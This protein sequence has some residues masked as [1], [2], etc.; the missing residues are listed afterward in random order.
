[1]NI[2]STLPNLDEI[3]INSGTDKSSKK[4]N[5]L[6][7]YEIFVAPLRNKKVKVMEIGVF[8][9]ASLRMW[10][11]YFP[12]GYV[13][14]VDNKPHTLVHAG[15]RIDVRH[16]DQNF[17]DGLA[18]LAQEFGPF[19]IIIDDGSHLWHHQINTMK[20]LL[21]LVKSGGIYIVEDLQTSF[22][23]Y[24]ANYGTPDGEPAARYCLKFA[25]RVIAD[26]AL[27]LDLEPDP[28]LAQASKLVRAV[29]FSNRVAVF[30]RR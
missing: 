27:K 21:P 24:I 22:G 26:R 15:E 9:G 20:A 12:D 13:L 11:D 18:N 10:R 30:L 4:H 6:S 16:G 5:Y 7:F 17:P 28:F 29:Q 14:G 25:E 1:M 2:S 19:D 23:E 3:G 8:N